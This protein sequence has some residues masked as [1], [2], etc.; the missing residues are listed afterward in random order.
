VTCYLLHIM[1]DP[2][3]EAYRDADLKDVVGLMPRFFCAQAQ[4]LSPLVASQSVK[5]MR[6]NAP[7]WKPTNGAVADDASRAERPGAETPGTAPGPGASPAPK[8]EEPPAGGN[9]YTF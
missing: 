5:C 8:K 9:P 2:D 4:P 3:R 6:R 1:E 7:C